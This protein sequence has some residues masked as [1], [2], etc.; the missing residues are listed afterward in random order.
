MAVRT[1]V[2]YYILAGQNLSQL[3]PTNTM[4]RS[5]FLLICFCVLGFDTL[6]IRAFNPR[7]TFV[8]QTSDDLP[9]SYDQYENKSTGTIELGGTV[10]FNVSDDGAIGTVLVFYWDSPYET[11]VYLLTSD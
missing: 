1:V 10:H 5:I 8:N 7:P 3:K 11:N 6:T 2:F 4:K 9:P